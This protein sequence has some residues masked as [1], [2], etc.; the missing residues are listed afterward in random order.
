MSA[1][2]KYQTAE[3]YLTNC[4]TCKI[5]FYLPGTVYDR[6][7]AS[8]SVS[9][10]CPNGHSSIYSDTE[11][12][13]LK[14]QLEQEKKRLE[15]ANKDLTMVRQQRDRQERKA[16]AFKGII[17]KT[18]KR[19]GQGVCPCCNRFFSKLHAHMMVKHPKYKETK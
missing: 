13:R 11:T 10:Y 3:H 16:R 7:Q 6:A 12:A 5:S 2:I 17:T 14:R 15:W 8:S 1:A 4:A 18:K 9:F 19:V